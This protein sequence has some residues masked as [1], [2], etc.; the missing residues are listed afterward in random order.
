MSNELNATLSHG[1]LLFICAGLVSA[2]SVQFFKHHSELYCSIRHLSTFIR[3]SIAVKPNSYLRHVVA[4][5][6]ITR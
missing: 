3:I 2:T 4:L 6:L 5:A 1:L